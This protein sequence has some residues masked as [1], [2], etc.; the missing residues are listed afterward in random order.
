MSDPKPKGTP[1]SGSSPGAPSLACPGCGWANALRA[2][3]CEFCRKPLGPQRASRPPQRVRS[4]EGAEPHDQ[5]PPG[6]PVPGKAPPP[7][8]SEPENESFLERHGIEITPRK[9]IFGVIVGMGLLGFTVMYRGNQKATTGDHMRRIV[10]VLEIFEGE[11]GG[12]PG[13]LGAVEMRY[14]PI[15]EPYRSDGWGNPIAYKA[16]EPRTGP[17]STSDGGTPLFGACELR[18][19]GPNGRAGDDDD[20]VWKSR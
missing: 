1:P 14:G 11:N 12:Y 2:T 4:P 5:I 17:G 8:V 19:S 13:E 9:V 6:A 16:S 3:S 7:A 18:S 10:K 20:V 15:T